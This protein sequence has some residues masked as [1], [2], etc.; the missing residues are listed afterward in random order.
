MSALEQAQEIQSADFILDEAA[1]AGRNVAAQK[2]TASAAPPARLLEQVRAATKETGLLD[3]TPRMA[4][5]KR[6]ATLDDGPELPDRPRGA[7]SR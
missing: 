3:T 7:R 1:R 4:D 6:S 5:L 2:A